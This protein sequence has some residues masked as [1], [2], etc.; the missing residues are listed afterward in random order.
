MAPP[1]TL[2]SKPRKVPAHPCAPP[3]RRA[4]L[5]PQ[6]ASRRATVAIS[7]Q[8][9]KTAATGVRVV[10]Q[11]RRLPV[12]DSIKEYVEKKIGKS[13]GDFA[14]TLRVRPRPSEMDLKGLVVG[15]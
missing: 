5:V 9:A 7:A 4:G 12:T 2:S 3:H 8:A 15:G 13:I 14:H 6:P 10:L 1:P 11:G